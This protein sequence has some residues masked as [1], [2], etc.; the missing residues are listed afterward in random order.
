[1]LRF[2]IEFIWAVDCPRLV[3]GSPVI[4]LVVNPLGF[5]FPAL[6]IFLLP[7]FF[8]PSNF[9]FLASLFLTLALAFT[10]SPALAVSGRRRLGIIGNLKVVI[11]EL[12]N[13]GGN[14]DDLFLLWVHGFPLVVFEDNLVLVEV[15]GRQLVFG[16]VVPVLVL[17]PL[18]IGIA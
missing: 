11:I 4:F 14:C 13:D 8:S 12:L 1:M 7:L 9:C 6:R 16:D 18:C 5:C 2:D 15:G 10:L 17:I 3:S